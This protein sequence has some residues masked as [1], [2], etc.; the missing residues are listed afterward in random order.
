MLDVMPEDR[1]SFPAR[2]PAELHEKLKQKAADT[3]GTTMNE[4]V[5]I[6]VRQV[7]DVD[8]EFVA[9]QPEITDAKAELVI[10]AIEDRDVGALKG[11]A[12]H[13]T[14]VG[15]PNLA[16]LL[17]WMSAEMIAQRGAVGGQ[18]PTDEA[19]DAAK[20]LV[21]TADVVSRRSRPIAVAL[22]RAALRHNPSSE[23]AKNR[24]GQLL[25]FAKDYEGAIGYLASVRERDGHAK[26]FH[27][28]ASLNLA[29]AAGNSTKTN[30]ARDEIVSALQ[31]WAFGMHDERERQSWLRQVADLA[32]LGHGFDHTVAELVVYANDNTSWR[33][34]TSA[35]VATA[36][37]A[38]IGSPG[39]VQRD[40]D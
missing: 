25:Y 23:V 37:D 39:P 29:M 1:R 27:G 9:T 15:R 20:E 18:A 21:R 8:I 38:S 2:L 12:Q 35:D 32:A 28:F 22:L 31:A 33:T 3:P 14:N 7:L 10:A 34:I 40:P 30:D 17:Y 36:R 11:T 5:V 6:G 19:K 26:L 4:L 13:Y 16:S 24:L